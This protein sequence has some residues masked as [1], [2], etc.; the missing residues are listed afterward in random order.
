MY[1]KSGRFFLFGCLGFI[2]FPLYYWIWTFLFPQAYENLTLRL[3]GSIICIPFIFALMVGE[4]KWIEIYFYIVITYAFPF[5]FTFMYLMNEASPVWSQSL[6]IMVAIIFSFDIKITILSTLIGATAGVLYYQYNIGIAEINYWHRIYENIPTIIF[7]ITS[8]SIIKIGKRVSNEEKL[9]TL[10]TGISTAAHELRNPLASIVVYIGALE[11][12]ISSA[13]DNKQLPPAKIAKPFSLQDKLSEGL[14]LIKSQIF[15]AN[16]T[17]NILVTNAWK[18][19]NKAQSTDHFEIKA[20]IINAIEL[21]PFPNTKKPKNIQ[22]QLE[23]N[24]YIKG[25]EKLFTLILH[26]LIKNAYKAISRGSHKNGI[27]IIKTQKNKDGHLCLSFKDNGCGIQKN[28]MPYLF[29]RFFS[30]PPNS[31]T[32]IGLAFCRDVLNEWGAKM[33]CLSKEYAYT[34]FIISFPPTSADKLPNHP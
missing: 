17:I 4:K 8:A 6:M 7:S 23:E 29:Q 3:I 12:Y 24:A 25:D 26:N 22:L 20:A 21:Y 18:G 5:F 10:A 33:T 30:Y 15:Y 1:T 19:K 2:G 9:G 34:E 32:G 27:I 16:S 13:T 28:H 11:K 31:G 14:T